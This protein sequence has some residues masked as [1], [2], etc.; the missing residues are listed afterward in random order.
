[1][2]TTVGE[3][4]ENGHTELSETDH[5]TSFEQLIIVG[6]AVLRQGLELVSKTLTDDSQLS[7]PS[8][9]IPGSTI[10]TLLA[11]KHGLTRILAL[12]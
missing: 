4:V 2:L 12:H 3:T 9:L 8:K 11:R 10:G 6:L 5:P 7:F 1:M